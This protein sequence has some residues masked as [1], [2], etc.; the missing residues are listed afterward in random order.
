MAEQQNL[1]LYSFSVHDPGSE[2]ATYGCVASSLDQA[3]RMAAFIGYKNVILLEA[4]HLEGM[5]I[6]RLA[7]ERAASNPLVGGE[8]LPLLDLM[9]EHLTIHKPGRTWVMNVFPHDEPFEADSPYVQALM[10]PEGVTHLEIGPT[11]V[12]EDN[13]ELP[14]E[15]LEFL[16]WSPPLDSRSPN[17]SVAFPPGMSVE[18]ITATALQ[19]LIV[20]FGVSTKDGFSLSGTRGAVTE[21]IP[22]IESLDPQEEYKLVEP[23]FG[24]S[25][26]HD[27]KF[28]TTQVFK[29][30]YAD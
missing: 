28:P 10:L 17:F 8:W 14:G 13:N 7:R 16:G 18:F 4:R 21:V 3:R 27:V 6:P 15:F 22:G 26:L 24:L 12:L 20:L 30:R 11:A 5:E 1:Q 2:A 25:A 23:V 19:A 9:A 29:E